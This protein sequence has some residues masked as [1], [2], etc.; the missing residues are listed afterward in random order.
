MFLVS[1]VF[2]VSCASSCVF[3]MSS[4]LC[5]LTRSCAACFASSCSRS[6]CMFACFHI[7]FRLSARAMST[8]CRL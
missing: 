6:L 8:V 3:T 2:V 4:L 1:I 7:A 5:V